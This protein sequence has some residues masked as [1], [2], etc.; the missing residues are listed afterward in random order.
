MPPGGSAADDGDGMRGKS[1]LRECR[2]G[3]ERGRGGPDDEATA[4]HV[5]SPSN[6]NSRIDSQNRREYSR[7]YGCPA[8]RAYSVS[9]HGGSGSSRIDQIRSRARLV[10]SGSRYPAEFTCVAVYALFRTPRSRLV[11]NDQLLSS[12]RPPDT[13]QI[14][15]AI[16][17][18]LPD[19]P[20]SH[21]RIDRSSEVFEECTLLQ[22]PS[23]GASAILSSHSFGTMR[24]FLTDFTFLTIAAPIQTPDILRRLAD[25]GLPLVLSPEGYGIFY[26]GPS[27]AS[28][29]H[30]A[31]VRGS[32]WDFIIPL[33]GDEFLRVPDRA[34]LEAA[35][36]ESGPGQHRLVGGRELHSH[37]ER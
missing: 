13:K 32:S 22:S 4:I 20:K 12:C 35:L 26:Q 19:I 16:V 27:R 7:M 15:A 17:P 33:D 34:T 24:H 23:C 8:R 29:A 14:D 11:H 25:D 36:A 10:A 37:R 2:S 31:C 3:R 1:L 5:L 18:P 9:G 28:A 6:R 30:Q 21:S